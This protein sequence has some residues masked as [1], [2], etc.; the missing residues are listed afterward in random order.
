MARNEY[1]KITFEDKFARK[2][3][4]EHTRKAILKA[5][6]K[7]NN[8][9]MRKYNKKLIEKSLDIYQFI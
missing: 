3:F 4:G 9:K 6:R 2:Y 7:T 1:K 5:E 8:N